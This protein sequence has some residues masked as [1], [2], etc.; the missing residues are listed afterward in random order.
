VITSSC[1]VATSRTDFTARA[2]FAGALT[3]LSSTP[4]SMIGSSVQ[5][6]AVS[7]AAI[8]TELV[9]T[10]RKRMESIRSSCILSSRGID[11][12]PSYKSSV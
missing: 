6:G 7:P 9:I 4:M 10:L 3:E 1:V 11:D 2:V 5:A 8:M 12:K